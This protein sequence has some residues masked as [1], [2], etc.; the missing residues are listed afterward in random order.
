M[1]ETEAHTIHA[2]YEGVRGRA[3]KILNRIERTDAYLD[4]LLDV[5]LRAP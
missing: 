4:K 2:L 5:E 3:V 1:S